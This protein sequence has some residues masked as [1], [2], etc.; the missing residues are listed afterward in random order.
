M[1]T[2]PVRPTNARP[3]SGIWD[4][5]GPRAPNRPPRTGSIA[6]RDTLRPS[7]AWEPFNLVMAAATFS[8]KP[9]IPEVRS[10]IFLEITSTPIASMT[11]AIA[12]L[13]RV[14]AL[15]NAVPMPWVAVRA[16]SSKPASPSMPLELSSRSALLKSS[17]E[18]VPVFIAS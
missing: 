8:P 2:G 5:S 14:P 12:R 13:M 11:A 3:M 6:D 4:S 7:N 9:T 15:M 17:K 10:L 18:T 16:C 1:P